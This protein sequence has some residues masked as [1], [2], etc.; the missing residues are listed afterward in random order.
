[1]SVTFIVGVDGS[2]ASNRA[3]AFAKR[4]A[5]LVGDEC[6]L[7]LVCVVEWS[8]YKF[9]TTE[10]NAIRHKQK[11]DEIKSAQQRVI[12]PLLEELK[13]DGVQAEGRVIHGKASTILN[14]MAVENNAEQIFVARST[15]QGLSARV[16]GSVTANLV[17]SSNVPVTVVS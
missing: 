10:E 17:M 14:N 3:L 7:L 9:Q 13:N 16:F 4:Q 11:L 12:D 2:D 6:K 5:T 8:P 1:M 15:E